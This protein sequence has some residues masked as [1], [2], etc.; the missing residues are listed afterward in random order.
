ML[1]LLVF[2]ENLYENRFCFSN[3]YEMRNSTHHILI[4]CFLHLK[5]KLRFRVQEMKMSVHENTVWKNSS[6]RFHFPEK[7]E[8][9]KWKSPMK[10]LPKLLSIIYAASWAEISADVLGKKR[11]I[12][13]YL[14]LYC[15]FPNWFRD[16][17]HQYLV[18][19]TQSSHSSN[20]WWMGKKKIAQSKF[21]QI[22]QIFRWRL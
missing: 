8:L 16:Q 6:L 17:W 11:N 19:V 7:E 21:P 10:K 3:D 4:L 2:L 13:Y 5:E 1:Y 18:T 9:S 14:E 12:V 22:D 20:N 15:H